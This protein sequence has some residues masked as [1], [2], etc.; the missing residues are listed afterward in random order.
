M[1]ITLNDTPDIK[2]GHRFQWE[3]AQDCFVILFPEGMVQLSESAGEILR[4]CDGTR[5]VT[6]IIMLLNEK[7]PDADLDDDVMEF[8]TEAQDNGWIQLK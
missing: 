7:F 1:T 3:E 4:L 2:Q 6:E 8:F 5:T